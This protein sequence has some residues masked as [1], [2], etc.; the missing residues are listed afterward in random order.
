MTGFHP[1]PKPRK[2]IAD[3]VADKRERDR[4][5]TEFRRQ[6]W[7]RDG[8]RCQWCFR[9]VRRTLELVPDAG[10]C[11]HLHGRNVRP[12]DRYNVD[13]AKLLCG[14]CHS[15]PQVILQLRKAG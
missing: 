1:C 8:S 5:A 3:R 11:H 13:A 4:K 6:I 7:F 14:E 9:H 15:D 12:E 2:R 10:H